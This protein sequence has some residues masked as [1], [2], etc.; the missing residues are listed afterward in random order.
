M[1]TVGGLLIHGPFW[2]GSQG[3]LLNP[4]PIRTVLVS[5]PTHGSS[6]SKAAFQQ[7]GFTT[8]NMWSL[9][10]LY[11]THSQPSCVIRRKMHIQWRPVFICFSSFEGSVNSLVKK[12][13]VEVCLLSHR[14]MSFQLNPYPAHYRP[15][16]AFS[17]FLCPHLYQPPLRERYGFNKFRISNTNGLDPASS[18]IA[19]TS[20]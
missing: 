6:L 14:I 11:N 2:S 3:S 13:H 15:A 12:D 7:P 10:S 18:P 20:V 9:F 4:S 17:T 8:S 1:V 19:I 16:F 5:F